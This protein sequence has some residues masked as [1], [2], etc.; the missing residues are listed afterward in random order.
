MK[1]AVIMAGHARSW[2]YCKSNF[3]ENICHGP[4]QIDVF[5]ETYNEFFRSDYHLH[6]E[7]D[8]KISHTDDEIKDM[9][10]EINVVNFGIEGEKLG[11][12]QIMHKRKLLKA[13]GNFLEHENNNGKY[14]LCIKHRFDI[15]LLK[16]SHHVITQLDSFF[17]AAGS[18]IR[19][20]V[21]HSDSVP[22]THEFL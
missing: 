21:L 6:N 15:V 2:D 10:K 7:C 20:K 19:I 11:P 4:H 14:D 9:F 13:F 8:M 12:S 18:A 16:H 22:S 1:I 17:T 5:C 3:I